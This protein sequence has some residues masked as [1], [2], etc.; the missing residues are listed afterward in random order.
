[1]SFI[2]LT[3]KKPTGDGLSHTGSQSQHLSRRSQLYICIYGK[4]GM[5]IEYKD[6]NWNC[7]AECLQNSTLE[8]IINYV[9]I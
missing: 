3:K 9:S 1:M 6:M 8:K 2:N 7:V 5:R 4:N